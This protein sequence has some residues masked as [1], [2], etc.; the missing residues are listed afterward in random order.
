MT[1]LFRALVETFHEL[2]KRLRAVVLLLT[3]FFHH[4][5]KVCEVSQYDVYFMG[6]MFAKICLENT[7]MRNKHWEKQMYAVHTVCCQ[8]LNETEWILSTV[9]DDSYLR[10]HSL[11]PVSTVWHDCGLS[12]QK[13][14]LSLCVSQINNTQQHSTTLDLSS[15]WGL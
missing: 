7:R 2:S 8:C 14:S 6:H 13:I 9:D 5:H 11:N 3:I 4:G 12:R 10:K 1:V 15:A